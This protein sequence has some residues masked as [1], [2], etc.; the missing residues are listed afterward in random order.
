MGKKTKQEVFNDVAR[1]CF[2][3]LLEQGFVE[4]EVK[5]YGLLFTSDNSSVYVSYDACEDG[6]TTTITATVGGRRLNAGRSSLYV[7]AGLGLAQDLR[8]KARSARVFP[9]RSEDEA[10]SWK[11]IHSLPP[12]IRWKKGSPANS[13]RQRVKNVSTACQFV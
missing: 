13:G 4:P 12:R 11:S 9:Q 3:F 8:H 5:D 1:K 2:G 10:A 7:G 6:V